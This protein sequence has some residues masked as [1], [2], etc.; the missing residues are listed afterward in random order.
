MS[1]ENL[2]SDLKK[3]DNVSA[4][5]QF[6]NMMADKLSAALDAKKIEIA[7]NLQNRKAETKQE[8]K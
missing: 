2:I 1:I 3:G 6:N 4:G 7:S 8:E 5:K